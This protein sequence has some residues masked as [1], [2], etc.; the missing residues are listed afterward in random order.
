MSMQHGNSTVHRDYQGLKGC[1][2]LALPFLSRNEFC[3]RLNEVITSLF[4][5]VESRGSNGEKIVN[6]LFLPNLP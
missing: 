1:G 5:Y 3:N 4:L 2:Q 6:F